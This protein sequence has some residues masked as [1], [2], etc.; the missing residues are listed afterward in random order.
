MA[1]RTDFP[2][3]HSEIFV[4][5]ELS[6]K[7]VAVVKSRHEAQKMLG[8]DRVVNVVIL[9]KLVSRLDEKQLQYAFDNDLLKDPSSSGSGQRAELFR[10]I[11]ESGQRDYKDRGLVS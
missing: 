4:G 7:L 1:L 9:E 2:E 3:S 8:R 6:C 11:A 5:V 10:R